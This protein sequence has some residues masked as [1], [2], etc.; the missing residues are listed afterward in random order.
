MIYLIEMTA[1][2]LTT[3]QVITRRFGSV[4]YTTLPTD[5][6]ANI[7]FDE[8]TIQPGSYERSVFANGTTSGESDIAFGFIELANAD[9]S[10]D[11]LTNVSV[12]GRELKIYGLQDKMTP[13]SQR[14]LLFVGTMEQIEFSWT[15][16]TIRIRDALFKLRQNIQPVLY[17][18]T[19][20]AGGQDT[21]EGT[22]ETLKDKPK[23]LLFGKVFNILPILANQFDRIYQVSSRGFNSGIVVRDAGV[24]LTFT[25]NYATIAALRSS[26]LTS[27]QF[28]TATSLGLFR[29]GGNPLGD[30]TVDVS[31][32]AD[33]SRSAARTVRR[34]LEG[35]GY[36]T[37]NFSSTDIEALHSLNPAEVGV[38]IGADNIDPL[39][40]ISSL[41]DS[42]GATMT[43]DR[44][45]VLRFF[46][47]GVPSG[48]P[49]FTFERYL[50]L[51]QGSG[52][53]RVATNDAG[54]G[55][56]AKKVTINYAQNYTLQSGTALAGATTETLKAFLKE[57][58]RTVKAEDSSVA[59]AFLLAPELEFTT[60]L[61]LQADAQAE[62][63][64]RLALYK[65]KRDRFRIPVKNEFV[66]T[67]EL[68]AVVSLKVNRFS[69]NAGKLFIVIGINEN[70]KTGVT[71]VDI[72]G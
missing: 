21:A 72:F 8:H 71:T 37:A 43:P 49:V 11:S 6:P 18:G 26:S 63:N 14:T 12:D 19:T 17:L 47:V 1:Y 58:Y 34:I 30:I 55:V 61:T 67:L 51:N 59:T 27:G 57:T 22:A 3:N 13:W 60:C 39:T 25:S 29:V 23:P 42:I 2:D 16:V 50:I 65:V 46:R 5:S 64:R 7:S 48:S 24:P 32:G 70:F 53:E 62:A 10:L 44:L 41:L 36:T 4:G 33:G 40:V 15:K 52:I 9:G 45:G 69:L 66:S 56:P 31:E 68:G 20:T 28:A 54:R 38:W 35:F